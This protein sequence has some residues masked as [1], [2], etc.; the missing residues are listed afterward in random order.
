MRTGASG[1]DKGSR[2]SIGNKGC[3]GGLQ[4]RMGVFKK[5]YQRTLASTKKDFP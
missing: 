1:R 5:L 2:V 3:D 4:R